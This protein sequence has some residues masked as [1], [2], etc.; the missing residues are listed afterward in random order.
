MQWHWGFVVAYFPT[1]DLEGLQVLSECVYVC[2]HVQILTVQFKIAS[3]IN[4]M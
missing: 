2:V 4:T 3:T 1:C